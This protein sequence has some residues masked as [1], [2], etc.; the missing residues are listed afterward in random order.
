MCR[1][2]DTFIGGAVLERLESVKKGPWPRKDH[3]NIS[4]KAQ[5]HHVGPP[6]PQ[7]VEDFSLKKGGQKP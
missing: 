6:H 1:L 4:L 5:K 3:Q 7:L 2:K